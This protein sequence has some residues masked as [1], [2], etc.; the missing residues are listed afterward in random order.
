MKD[1]KIV[2]LCG[3]TKFKKEFE[4]AAKNETLH[5]KIVLTCNLFNHYDN[6]N[7]SELTKIMLDEMHFKKIELADEIFVINVDGYIGS[8]TKKEIEYAKLLGK[9]IRYLE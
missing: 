1:F 9:I 4:E 2:C 3:S 6:L 5:R 8:S 7:I